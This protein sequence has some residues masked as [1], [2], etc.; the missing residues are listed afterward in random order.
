M[1]CC[2]IGT[3]LP[4]PVWPT[5][6]LPALGQK[7]AFRLLLKIDTQRAQSQSELPQKQITS[8]V[9]QM[10]DVAGVPRNVGCIFCEGYTWVCIL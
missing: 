10:L 7:V 9:V 3:C 5:P 6:I 2:G 8:Q 4:T 1:F